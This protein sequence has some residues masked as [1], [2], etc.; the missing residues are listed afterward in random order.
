MGPY[1]EFSGYQEKEEEEKRLK[2]EEVH[3]VNVSLRS[4]TREWTMVFYTAR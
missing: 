1:R 2:D 4:T 3:E